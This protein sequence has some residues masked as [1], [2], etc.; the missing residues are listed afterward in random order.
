[1][2][3]MRNIVLIVALAALLAGV[4]G[5]Q[6]AAVRAAPVAAPAS[7]VSAASHSGFVSEDQLWSEFYHAEERHNALLA[8][9][10]MRIINMRHEHRVGLPR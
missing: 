3:K 9:Q 4:F 5:F 6:V 1:M 8:V 10:L 7:I 2:S